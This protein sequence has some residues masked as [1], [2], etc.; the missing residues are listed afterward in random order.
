MDRFGKILFRPDQCVSA[1]HFLLPDN[2]VRFSGVRR[3]SPK[4]V[5]IDEYV[6]VAGHKRT[7][8]MQREDMRIDGNPANNLKPD[9][10][11]MKRLGNVFKV[12]NERMHTRL[13]NQIHAAELSG[14]NYEL[15]KCPQTEM[16]SG[17]F[18][19]HNRFILPSDIPS[20]AIH[21]TGS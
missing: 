1:H 8:A 3:D 15:F 10:R 18:F 5:A 11:G 19:R 21:A 16:V 6:D 17:N 14:G 13:E 12:V 20:R 9:S 4:V 7:T 2:Q